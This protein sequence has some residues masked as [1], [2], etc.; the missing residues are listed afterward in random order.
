MTTYKPITYGVFRESSHF[1]TH[2]L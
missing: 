2:K 1:I